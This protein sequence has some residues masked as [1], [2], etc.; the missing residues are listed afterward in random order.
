MITDTIQAQAL[1]ERKMDELQR[2]VDQARGIAADLLA[3]NL[4]LREQMR[5]ALAVVEWNVNEE[6]YSPELMEY[7]SEEPCA[8]CTLRELLHAAL[9][10]DGADTRSTQP[11]GAAA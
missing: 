10:D 7:V 5:A 2:Q 3:E 9:D 8:R 1:A 6:C 4:F 11:N